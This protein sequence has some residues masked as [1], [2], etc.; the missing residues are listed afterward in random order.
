MAENRPLPAWLRVIL[1]LCG[2]VGLAVTLLGWIKPIVGFIVMA[3]GVVYVLWEIGPWLVQ[4]TRRLPVAATLIALFAGV[5]STVT[6]ACIM[7]IFRVSPLT[8]I[9]KAPLPPIIQEC[10]SFSQDCASMRPSSHVNMDAEVKRRY[11]TLD[12]LRDQYILDNPA[13]DPDLLAKKIYPPPDWI[14]QKLQAIGEPWRFEDRDHPFKVTEYE[15]M[16]ALQFKNAVESLATEL[17]QFDI[18]SRNAQDAITTRYM[19]QFKNPSEQNQQVSWQSMNE[20]LRVTVT[21][22]EVDFASRY[23]SKCI[24]INMELEKRTPNFKPNDDDNEWLHFVLKRLH[25][26]RALANDARFLSSYF[27]LRAETIATK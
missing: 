9:L 17:K 12:K 3:I 24:A 6:I 2:P 7:H 26:G 21:Q 8:V 22:E 13:S 25:E 10:P 16:T 20:S 27:E 23:E 4:Q 19:A 15:P 1:N 14:N 11:A 5:V 18:T